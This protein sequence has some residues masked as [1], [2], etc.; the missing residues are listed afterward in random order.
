MSGWMIAVIAAAAGAALGWFLNNRLGAFSLDAAKQKGEEI[1]RAAGREAES[2]K[3]QQI[4]EAR[5]QILREKSKAEGDLRS[6]KG[7]VAKRERELKLLR[8][9]LTELEADVARQRDAVRDV[10]Q[11]LAARETE[12]RHGQEALE[13]LVHEENARLE[14]ASG[15]TRARAAHSPRG[16]GAPGPPGRDAA[17]SQIGRASCRERV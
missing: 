7:Q 14:R 11:G 4:V 3:R 15:L 9:S 1:Q 13:H 17:P 8:D 2:L 5:E 16:R 12:L 6:R 10:E